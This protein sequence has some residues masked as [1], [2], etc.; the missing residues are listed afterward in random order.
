M[1]RESGRQFR[2]KDHAKTDTEAEIVALDEHWQGQT[3]ASP[4]VLPSMTVAA[5]IDNNQNEETDE[6]APL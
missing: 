2:E 4:L 1:I 3:I 6:D 5:T